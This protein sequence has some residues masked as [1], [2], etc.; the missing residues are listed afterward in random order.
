MILNLL[1]NVFSKEGDFNTLA[2]R[3]Q[4][5]SRELD[6]GERIGYRGQMQYNEPY[7]G[8]HPQIMDNPQPLATLS[9]RNDGLQRGFQQDGEFFFLDFR[10]IRL[11]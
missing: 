8:S 3:S 1:E 5:N 9:H 11:F 10:V 4:M 7:E 6:Y 2:H